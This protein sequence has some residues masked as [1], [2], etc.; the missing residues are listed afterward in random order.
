MFMESNDLFPIEQKGC[1]RG[2]C[3]CKNQLLINGMIFKDCKSKLRNLSM[4]WTDY[5]TAFDSVPH[6]WILKVLNLFKLSSVL[7]NFLRIN[8]SMWET[9][10]NLTD[11]NGNL[12]S[13]PIKIN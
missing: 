2:S 1:I 6:S 13:K 9:T 11:Q 4:A 3:S 12:K 5:R 10:L 8:M 7:I